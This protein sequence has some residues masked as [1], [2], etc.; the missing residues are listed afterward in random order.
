MVPR[1]DPGTW[2]IREPTADI[3]TPD[4]IH[5]MQ[6]INPNPTFDPEFQVSVVFFMLFLLLFLHLK[7]LLLLLF[8]MLLHCC[9]SFNCSSCCCCCCCCFSLYC[10]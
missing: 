3:F 4:S 10:L 7:L 6:N 1:D 8:Q 5:K 9:F 2:I